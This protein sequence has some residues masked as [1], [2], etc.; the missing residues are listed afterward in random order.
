MTEFAPYGHA[1]ASLVLF[2]LIAMALAPIAATAKMKDGVA[3]GGTPVEDYASRA[4]RLHRA[5]QNAAESLPVFVAV[6]VAAMLAGVSPHW[7]NWLASLVI[8]ARLAMLYFHVS[9]KGDP[10][11]G[12]RSMAYAASMLCY[13]V[14]AIL[15][16]VMVF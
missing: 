14:M 15:T 7:V 12:P 1:I 16:L 11:T 5:Q 10:Y 6:T 8:V 9:G 2:A 13:L 4:Y 3:P